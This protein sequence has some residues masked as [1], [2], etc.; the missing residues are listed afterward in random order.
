[1][2]GSRSNLTAE[3]SVMILLHQILLPNLH[4]ASMILMILMLNQTT[5]SNLTKPKSFP[6]LTL[7]WMRP[8]ILSV[9]SQTHSLFILTRLLIIMIRE[10]EPSLMKHSTMSHSHDIHQSGA[11][12][13]ILWCLILLH[14]SLF[15]LTFTRIKFMMTDLV[16]QRLTLQTKESFP[17][18]GLQLFLVSQS[19][20]V[21]MS[22][23]GSSCVWSSWHQLTVSRECQL[24][25][26]SCCR[27]RWPQ[28]RRCSVSSQS[29]RSGGS[30]RS[31]QRTCQ[32]SVS[33]YKGHFIEVLLK[34]WF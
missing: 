6:C 31:L 18:Q 16:Y 25:G 17:L 4:S 26:I 19:W 14:S 21:Q 2:V 5:T 23:R 34:N 30:R 32:S 12:V 13:V 29:R 28:C 10:W 7:M 3:P 24:T 15:C 1:M 20:P 9:T 27:S 33:R 22:S 8:S 11:V